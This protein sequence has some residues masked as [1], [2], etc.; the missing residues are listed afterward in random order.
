M[1][2]W[3]IAFLTAGLIVA[4]L[5][6]TVTQ[7]G[8]GCC[9]GA[10]AKLKDDQSPPQTATQFT[11]TNYD[12]K[13]ISLADFK[14]KIVVL[15]WLNYDCP[16]VKYHYETET[17]MV[18]LAKK[19][20]D[21]DVVWLGINTTDYATPEANKAFAEKH[22]APYPI[23]DDH[24]G[25]VGRA[26]QATNTPGMFVID[27]EGKIV[28]RGAIDNAPFGRLNEGQTEKINYVDKALA[29]LTGGREVST[30]KTEPYGCTVKYA[31]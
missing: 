18:N 19:Y 5:A 22:S 7:A 16:F 14:G 25:N 30:P 17:T 10:A 6:V 2:R 1:T 27:K 11:L 29:E 20:A 23:L 4:A 31:K 15:E 13:E 8:S 21:K 12:G 26:Y 3:Q 24:A 28:Y 9:P